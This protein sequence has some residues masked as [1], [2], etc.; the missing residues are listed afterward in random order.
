MKSVFSALVLS[1]AFSSLIAC[2]NMSDNSLLTDEPSSTSS[3]AVDKTPN[4]SNMYLADDGNG[5]LMYISGADAFEITGSCSFSTYPTHAISVSLLDNGGNVTGGIAA[6]DMNT[7][8]VTTAAQCVKGRFHISIYSSSLV[9]GQ[10]SLR[11]SLVAYDSSS[12]IIR[13]DAAASR[14]VTVIK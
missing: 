2:S 13:N 10:N 11:I 6:L 14:T 1:L 4:S 5:A 8:S 7:G 9:S 12:A 3:G